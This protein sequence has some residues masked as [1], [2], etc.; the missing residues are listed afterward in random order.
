MNKGGL[1]GLVAEV[2]Q[3]FNFWGFC[4]FP[5]FDPGVSPPVELLRGRGWEVIYPSD[6]N[7]ETDPKTIFHYLQTVFDLS[8]A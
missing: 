5:G 7:P 6:S 2:V 8:T 4:L 3:K 1:L